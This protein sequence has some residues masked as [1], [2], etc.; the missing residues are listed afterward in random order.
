MCI[1]ECFQNDHSTTSSVILISLAR[2]RVALHPVAV[3]LSFDYGYHQDPFAH[4]TVNSLRFL[5]DD[6]LRNDN[7]HNNNKTA[8]T[9]ANKRAACQR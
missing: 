4:T 7:N 6:G 2:K 3:L 1:R 9:N 5:F 8:A